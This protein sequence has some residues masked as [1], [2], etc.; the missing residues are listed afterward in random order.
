MI[1]VIIFCLVFNYYYFIPYENP[2]YKLIVIAPLAICV[3]GVVN[4]LFKFW[5]VIKNEREYSIQIKESRK[6]R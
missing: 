2:F 3:Y 6:N 1:G 4:F 5:E